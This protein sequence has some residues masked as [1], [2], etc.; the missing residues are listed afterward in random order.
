M[1]GISIAIVG[2][3][4]GNFGVNFQKY[5]FMNEA[6]KVRG[7]AAETQGNAEIDTLVASLMQ[8]SHLRRPYAKQPRWWF[9]MIMVVVGAL[10]NFA[11]FGTY[12]SMVAFEHDFL[13]HYIMMMS[14]FVLQH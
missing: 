9:G 8:P 1:Q 2:S 11:A 12:S 10:S 3:V 13:V 4:F 7:Q 5:S 14:S 6:E